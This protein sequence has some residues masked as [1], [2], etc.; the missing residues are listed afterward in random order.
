MQNESNYEKIVFEPVGTFLGKITQKGAKLRQLIPL[1]QITV[2]ISKV[3][4]IF[5]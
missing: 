5:L 3:H 2:L 4:K 1:E